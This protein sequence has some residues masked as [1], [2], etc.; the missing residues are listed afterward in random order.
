MTL[1]CIQTIP[2]DSRLLRL[3]N[4]SVY[5]E[6]CYII[7]IIIIIIIVLRQVLCIVSRWPSLAASFPPRKW[8]TLTSLCWRAVKHPINQSINQSINQ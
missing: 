1:N 6:L 8:H 3:W 2:L 5:C 4:W 7:I